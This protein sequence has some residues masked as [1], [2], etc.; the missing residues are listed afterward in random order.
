MDLACRQV[1]SKWQEN[2]SME[3]QPVLWI[4]A[5]NPIIGGNVFISSN[6]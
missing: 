6:F 2:F 4:I 1:V 5:N 3:Q